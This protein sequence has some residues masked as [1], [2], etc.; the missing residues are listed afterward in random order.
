MC[1]FV[2]DS[3]Y[4]LYV[5]IQNN[6]KLK[7][8]QTSHSSLVLTQKGTF[9]KHTHTYGAGHPNTKLVQTAS[10]FG[11]AFNRNKR[12]IPAETAKQHLR[13]YTSKRWQR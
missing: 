6:L 8:H 2:R 12:G 10:F 4:G 13:K 11:C 5:L 1:T 3:I 9:K 7:I